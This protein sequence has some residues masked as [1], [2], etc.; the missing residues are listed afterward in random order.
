[1]MTLSIYLLLSSAISGEENPADVQ[2]HV[3]RRKRRLARSSR[4]SSAKKT[5]QHLHSHKRA[6]SHPRAAVHLAPAFDRHSQ[7]PSGLP[8]SR[9]SKDSVEDIDELLSAHPRE[10]VQLHTAYSSQALHL[11]DAD[12]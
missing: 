4:L 8:A 3:L 10:R 11:A 7:L 12:R 2:N 6:G 1:M 9:S 5:R